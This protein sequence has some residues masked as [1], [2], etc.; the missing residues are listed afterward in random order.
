MLFSVVFPLALASA[1]GGDAALEAKVAEFFEDSC[2]MCHQGGDDPTDP[3]NLKLSGSPSALIGK[4]SAALT[5]RP[6][7]KPGD[8]D[9]SYLLA[10]MK[11]SAGI[12]GDVMAPGDPPAPEQIKLVAD[13]IASLPP[14]SGAAV[15]DPPGTPDDDGAPAAKRPGRKPFHGTSQINLPTTTTL[16]EKILQYRIDHRFGRIGTERGAYGLDLGAIASFGLAYGILDGWDVNLR[17]T[18]TF[19]GWELGTKYAAIRQEDGAPLSLAGYASGDFH[20]LK[21]VNN[22]LSGNLMLM[23]SRLWYDRWSTMLTVGYHFNTNHNGDPQVDFDDGE[24]PVLV[25]DN[26]DTLAAGFASSIWL[27]KKKRWGIDL[28]Y[29]LPIPDGQSTNIFYYNGGDADPNGTKI[30]AWAFGGS[31]YTGK[32]F[33]QVLLTNNRQIHIQQAATGGQ[34]KNPFKTAGVDSKNP[35]HKLNFFAG[36][37]LGR[38]FTMGRRIEAAKKRKKKKQAEKKGG[39]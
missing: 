9:G 18:S 23:L 26:R 8:P 19:K 14:S 16:G 17:R 27:G 11:G 10:K 21:G 36:F 34:T 12:E 37:N 20:R 28:E 30:G 15:G 13:W 6:L 31:Y 33:F 7:I 38:R 5:D 39:N 3:G 25:D 24:G 29:I 1:P 32:H 4:N 35:F 22:R 2:T